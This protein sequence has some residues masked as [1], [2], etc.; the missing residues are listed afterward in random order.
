MRRLRWASNSARSPQTAES[1]PPCRPPAAALRQGLPDRST[2]TDRSSFSRPK[3]RSGDAEVATD[4]G[5]CLVPDASGLRWPR[6]AKHGVHP[7][8]LPLHQCERRGPRCA[9]AFKQSWRLRAMAFSRPV[10]PILETPT[11]QLWRGRADE[12]LHLACMRRHGG[13]A[14]VFGRSPPSC[15]AS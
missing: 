7:F 10:A 14:T 13:P 5:W 3:A 11:W 12:H 1:A 8:P 9:A 6:V 15:R 2:T 4:S